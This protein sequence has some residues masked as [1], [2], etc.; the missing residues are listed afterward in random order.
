[1]T[2]ISSDFRRLHEAPGA[3]IIPNPWDAGTARILAA[4]G[5]KALATTSAGM[6]FAMGARE[7]GIKRDAALAHCRALVAATPLPVSADLENGF[8]DSPESVAKTI[9][10]AAAV[11]LAGGSIEDYTGRTERPI[12]DF[13]LAVERIQAAAEARDTLAQD[14]VL[15]ARCENYLWGKPDLDDTIGRLQAFE[16]VGADVLY[17]PGLRD[18]D[19][20]RAVCGALAKPVNVI[21]GIPGATFSMA[22]LEQ[23]GVKRISAGSSLSRLAL[24]AF[25]RAAEAM[26]D[27][28]DFTALEGALGFSDIER[29]FPP[30]E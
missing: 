16:K 30:R 25:I 11:G 9:R 6:S 23:A 12:Y 10:A 24:G 4:L 21:A 14:F 8:G 7:G 3:F 17:A 28:G 2:N 27:A 22:Q 20:I 5:F 15:T 29:Y 19:A 26:A 1:M 18:L 13:Q